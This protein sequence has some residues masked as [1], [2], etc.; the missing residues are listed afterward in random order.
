MEDDTLVKIKKL[1]ANDKVKQAL[2][3]L[4]KYYAY[5]KSLSNQLLILSSR[6]ERHNKNKRL[7]IEKDADINSISNA[8]LELIAFIEN[9]KKEV[10]YTI[11]ESKPEIENDIARVIAKFNL[12]DLSLQ[13]YGAIMAIYRYIHFSLTKFVKLRIM[14]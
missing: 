1:I 9:Q 4:L 14:M 5:D 3:Q 7:G 6:F 13:T 12:S 8:M 11:I 2:E 10:I